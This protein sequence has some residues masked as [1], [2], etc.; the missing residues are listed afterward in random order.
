M[1][2]GYARVSTSHQDTELQVLAL[3]TAGCDVILKET[4]VREERQASRAYRFAPAF[5]A[6]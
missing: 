2:Y 5:G 6:W 4:G 1:V 3:K